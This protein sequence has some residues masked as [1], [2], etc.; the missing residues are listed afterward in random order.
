MIDIGSSITLTPTGSSS[1]FSLD[2]L[3]RPGLRRNPRR[4]HLLVS[5]VLGKHIP[6]DP[7][8]VADAAGRLADLVLTAVGGSDVDVLGFA[9]TAT[10]LGHGVAAHL[11]AHCYL[12]STRREVPGT[13]V[14]AE[15]QEGHSHA[16]DHRLLPTSTDVMTAALPLVLVDDEISTG[17][18]ALE[19]L[20]SL[21][22][23]TPRARYV[24]ASLVDM[25]TSEH[26]AQTQ[27]VA[28]ELGVV[29]D[30]VSLAQGSVE[31]ASDLVETVIAL[32]EPRYNPIGAEPGSISRVDVPWPATV[33]DG[34]GTA[35][36]PPTPW[37]SRQQ[38]L[39]RQPSSV[40]R[41]IPHVRSSSSVT[42]S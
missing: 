26:Q 33:P 18:T 42:K 1:T 21:H 11:G 12:H 2:Q 10:G 14:Y 36:S 19:A 27:S 39:T 17:R 5:E 32:P 4:A 37:P 31:L 8:L 9:E 23:R 29:I 35:S 40:P 3:V 24:I 28:H 38:S 22:A 16:T 34:G 7:V 15:F 25:R 20:R 41:S 13:V 6:V 30:S